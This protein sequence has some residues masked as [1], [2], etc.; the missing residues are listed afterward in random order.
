MKQNRRPSWVLAAI[1]LLVICVTLFTSPVKFVSGAPILTITPISWGVIGLDSNNVNVGPNKFMIG[2]RVCNTGDA[3][4][5][6]VTT[7]FNWTSSNSFISLDPGSASTLIRPSLNPGACADFYFNIVVTR[8]PA[9]RDTS[10]AYN[11]SATAQGLG[12][13]TTPANR[14]LYVERILS[15]SRNV[16]DSVTGPTTVVVGSTATY[17][18]TGGTATQGYEQLVFSTYF[19]NTIFEILSV[20]QTY[21]AP[22]NSTNDKEYADA[23]GWDPVVGSP[24]Y[25][26]CIGPPNYS[27]GKAGGQTISS[28]Y[29]VRIVGTGSAN[30]GALILDFSGSSYHYNADFG[31]T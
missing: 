23:C 6:N 20:T 22:P 31:Q 19:P 26:S 5:I 16:V 18:V 15:Q 17:T 2:A 1:A 12:T 3:T 4:A 30:L 13:V 7:T 25:R 28:V 27:G 14:E 21:S 11:I 10:R 24:T 8:D 29:T 9:A